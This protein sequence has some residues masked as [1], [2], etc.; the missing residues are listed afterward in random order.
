MVP[1]LLR[2]GHDRLQRVWFVA[3]TKL[4]SVPGY[5]RAAC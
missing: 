4:V 3:V 5:L 1:V 2:T